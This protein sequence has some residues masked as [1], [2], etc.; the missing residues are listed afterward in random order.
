MQALP[1]RS[2]L[3]V[4]GAVFVGAI[5]LPR[6]AG[7][8]AP[9]RTLELGGFVLA[10]ILTAFLRVQAPATADR[11]IMP[12]AFVI[13][14]SALMLFGPHVAMFVAAAAALTPGIVS[15]RAPLSL[16][17]VDA[18]IV[19]AATQAAGLAHQ[20]VSSVAVMFVWPWLAV[21]IT[22]AVLA[23]HLSLIHI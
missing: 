3:A 12:P 22:A 10:A 16:M 6:L 1:S 21:P 5:V 23:Y 19:I 11:A 20:S 8:A 7:W 4:L 15:A 18:A 13:V 2:S 14:F 17:F 9:E